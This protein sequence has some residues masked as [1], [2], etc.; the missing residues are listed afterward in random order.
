M[1]RRRLGCLLYIVFNL[2][3]TAS[4][5]GPCEVG[6]RPG[7]TLLYPYFE[8]DLSRP[9]GLTTLLSINSESTEH[10]LTR[11]V[12]WTDSA[13][14]AL[15]FDVL[16]KPKS[17]VTINMRDV[18]NG[19]L[20]KTDS[21]E[22]LQFPNCVSK[23]PSYPTTQPFGG[24]FDGS[25]FTV[26]DIDQRAIGYVTVDTVNRCRGLSIASYPHVGEETPL[27]QHYYDALTVNNVLWGDLLYVDPHENS[28][29]G[30]EAV[31]LRGDSFAIGSNTFYGRYV[32]WD[33]RDKRPNLPSR[34]SMRFLNGGAFGGGTD[35]IVFRNADRNDYASRCPPSWYPLPA[36]EIIVRDEAGKSM[37]R[38]S[39]TGVFGRAT[40]RVRVTDILDYS[41]TTNFGRLDLALGTA[42]GKSAGAWVIPIMTASGRFSVG[43]DAQPIDTSCGQ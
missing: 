14:P 17:V 35:A 28:A 7:T 29:Q 19:L 10:V 43:F 25:C 13:Y 37:R 27:G 32:Q 4:F 3:P 41:V 31:A 36:E 39:K 30:L 42:D 40:Q 6:G 15:S 2:V 1:S 20:P 8:V 22:V 34:W 5:T 24:A 38:L 23:P 18:M 11:V 26:E 33:G 21:V 9:D 16:L 12:V